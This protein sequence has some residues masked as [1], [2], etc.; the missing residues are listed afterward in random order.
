MTYV[1]KMPKIF[2]AVARSFTDFELPDNIS[3]RDIILEGACMD[4]ISVGE[5]LITSESEPVFEKLCT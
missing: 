5:R 4:F 1:T 2:N 3:I